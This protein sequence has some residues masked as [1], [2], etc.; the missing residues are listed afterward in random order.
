[1]NREPDRVE[2][3]MCHLEGECSPDESRRLEALL[4]TDPALRRLRDFLRESTT[5]EKRPA[6]Y[7]LRSAARELSARMFRDWRRMGSQTDPPRGL[8]VYDSKNLPIPE[9]V[10]PA[11]VDTRRLKY[12]TDDMELELSLYPV[13][14]NAYELVGQVAGPEITR[15]CRIEL[16]SE[17][18]TMAAATD[19]FCLF[20]VPRLPVASYTLTV[21]A[22]N[23][24]V[25]VVD[26]DL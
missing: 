5:S 22:D 26:I 7:E 11:V 6:L 24:A 3:L 18:R 1:M 4:K 19:E 21:L 17:A 23:R 12:K 14:L 20:Y 13:A 16:K 9:G 8:A 15:P 25:A 2:L 10:R